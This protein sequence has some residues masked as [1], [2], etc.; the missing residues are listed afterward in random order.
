MFSCLDICF[1]YQIY[2]FIFEYMFSYML[3]YLGQEK[4]VA[5]SK[6]EEDVYIN[7]HTVRHSLLVSILVFI[8]IRLIQQKNVWCL[9]LASLFCSSRACSDHTG[10]ISRGDMHAVSHSSNNLTV[11]ERLVKWHEM[12]VFSYAISCPTWFF[13]YT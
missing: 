9:S 1:H 10:K 2:V 6:Y 12:Y 4:A 8:S 5:K 7:N 13:V 11:Q 3:S